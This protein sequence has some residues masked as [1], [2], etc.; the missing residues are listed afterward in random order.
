MVEE[1]FS[2]VTYKVNCGAYGKPQ[3]IHVNRMRLKNPQ[4]LR[5][6]EIASSDIQDQLTDNE[7]EEETLP[8]ERNSCLESENRRERRRPKYLSDYVVDI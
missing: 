6:E 1:K 8:L 3:V 2:D 7:Q 5:G 4:V